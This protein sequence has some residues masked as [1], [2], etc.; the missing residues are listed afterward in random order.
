[1]VWVNETDFLK[2]PLA[3]AWLFEIS[4]SNLLGR[5][6]MFEFF[7][8]SQANKLDKKNRQNA[9]RKIREVLIEEFIWENEIAFNKL[10]LT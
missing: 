1:M 2:D 4:E 5:M 9:Y 10:Y 8:R 3:L 6:S 7:L